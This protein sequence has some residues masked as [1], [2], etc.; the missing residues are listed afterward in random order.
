MRAAVKKA[1]SNLHVVVDPEAWEY[2]EITLC[3]RRSAWGI[4]NESKRFREA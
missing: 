1:E 2:F 4:T 3:S